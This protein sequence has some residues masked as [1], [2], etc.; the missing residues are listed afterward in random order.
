MLEQLFGSRTRWKLLK[1]FLSQPD[2]Q[3]F[4]R[5]LERIIEEKLNSVR[6]E[7]A[8][9]EQL[10]VIHVVPERVDEEE[11][12]VKAG[13]RQQRKF[14]QANPNFVLFNEMKNM[15]TKSWLIAEK[16]LVERINELGNISY[17]LLAGRFVGDESSET[18]IL[19]IG[20]VD[21]TKLGQLMKT[22]AKNLGEGIN[23]TVMT[24][25]EYDYRMAVTD[26]FLYGILEREY[27]TVIDKR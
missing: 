7:L 12:E 23:Y 10:G 24:Q 5:E 9:L 3:F 18:D 25:K 14:Y 15:I 20:S 16:S 13:G 21:R 17:M 27:I 4:V 6:R 2:E 11:D 1:L 19:I 26:R 8:N 22:V